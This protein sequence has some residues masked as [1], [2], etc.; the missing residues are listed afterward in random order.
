VQ[1][2]HKPG[3]MVNYGLGAVITADI[4]QRIAQQLGPFA[5]GDPRWYGWLS[6]H[7][8][9]SGEEHQTVELLREFLGRPVTP[10]ALLGELRRI[11]P[12]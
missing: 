11:G 12:E 3:Y 7:L 5:T 4:R 1:L 8:L 6:E 2:V 9:S 10:D